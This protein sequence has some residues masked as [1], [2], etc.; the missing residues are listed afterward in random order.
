MMS[1]EK[2]NI[3]KILKQGEKEAEQF[4]E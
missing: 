2:E 3:T 4:N 1:R